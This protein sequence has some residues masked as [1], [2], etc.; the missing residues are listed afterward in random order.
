MMNIYLQRLLLSV[1]IGSTGILL[2]GSP[3]VRAENSDP[4]NNIDAVWSESDGIRNEIFYSERKDGAWSEPVMIS[5]DYYDNM[6]PVIDRDSSGRRWVFWSGYDDGHMDLRY[7]SGLEAQWQEVAS[8]ESP[9][10]NNTAPSVLIDD[11][12]V[13][14][15]VWAANDGALDDIFYAVHRQ[16]RWTEPAPVNAPNQ[17]P[18]ILPV[19]EKKSADEIMVSWR[20][21]IGGSYE[22]VFSVLREGDQW[23]TPTV[24]ADEEGAPEKDGA[25]EQFVELPPGRGSDGMVFLRVY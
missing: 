19:L 21:L 25:V 15:L 23:S 20:T 2:S 11:E 6:Y 7:T 22:Q 18:D 12:D 10:Q 24:I 8:L 17:V 14:W 13:I 9:M 1:L 16:N 3:S 5:D 4:K